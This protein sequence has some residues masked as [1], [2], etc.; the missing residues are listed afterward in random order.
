MVIHMT[1]LIWTRD[2]YKLGTVDIF[3]FTC[4]SEI[5]YISIS[6][7]EIIFGFFESGRISKTFSKSS[8]SPRSSY[9]EEHGRLSLLELLACNIVGEEVAQRNTE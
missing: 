4:L 6:H 7:V 3:L 2:V 1:G 9:Q 8:G 5:E